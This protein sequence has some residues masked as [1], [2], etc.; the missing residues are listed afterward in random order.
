MNSTFLAAA[1][2]A[3]LDAPILNPMSLEMMRAVDT[4]RVIN[5]Q[6]LGSVN[7]IKKYSESNSNFLCNPVENSTNPSKDEIH[8]YDTLE[9]LIIDGRK[10]EA[11]EQVRI[12][13]K[14]KEPLEIIDECFIPALNKVGDGFDKGEIFLPSLMMSAETVKACFDVIKAVKGSEGASTSKG[15][16]LVATVLGDIHDIGKNIA[17]M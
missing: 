5:C 6:D 1:M 16:I 17:K 14:A 7:Y 9:E 8:T 12:L 3:G 4:Y 15:K 11:A 13:L 10:E 2:G